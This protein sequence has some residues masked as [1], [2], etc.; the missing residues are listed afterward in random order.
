MGVEYSYNVV[1]VSN[2]RKL[3]TFGGKLLLL[4][5]VQF[6]DEHGHVFVPDKDVLVEMGGGY[7]DVVKY[8]ENVFVDEE[9]EQFYTDELHEKYSKLCNDIGYTAYNTEKFHQILAVELATG[10]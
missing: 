3:D 6:E 8:A 2:V 4:A 9:Y 1:G 10:E 5:D 7:A